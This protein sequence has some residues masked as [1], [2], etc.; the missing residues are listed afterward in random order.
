MLIVEASSS[1]TFFANGPGQFQ[2]AYVDGTTTT[3]DYFQDSF[4]IGGVE[5]A[6]MQVCI[7]W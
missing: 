1:S 4:G 5:L 7:A 3:G 2:A 6:D